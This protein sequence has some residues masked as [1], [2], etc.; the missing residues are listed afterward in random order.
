ME[1]LAGGEEGGLGGEGEI[2]WWCSAPGWQR[3][4]LERMSEALRCSPQDHAAVTVTPLVSG[5]WITE[6]DIWAFGGGMRIHPLR[7][8]LEDLMK[9]SEYD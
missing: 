1:F 6:D 3:A 4:G 8:T 2:E 5:S 9:G 7:K